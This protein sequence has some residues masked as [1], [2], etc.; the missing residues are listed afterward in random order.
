[1]TLNQIRKNLDEYFG[2]FERGMNKKMTGNI[3]ILDE[4]GNSTKLII[5]KKQAK[6]LRLDVQ[7]GTGLAYPL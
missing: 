3:I 4:N 6:E 5:T 2:V 7:R 1:M